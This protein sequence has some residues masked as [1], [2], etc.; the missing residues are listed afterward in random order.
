VKGKTLQ[1]TLLFNL[2]QYNQEGE[3]PTAING[4]DLPSWECP[5][6]SAGNL[7]P[8]G[9]ISYLTYRWRRCKLVVA[10]E[11]VVK[12]ASHPG[13]KL[14]KDLSAQ[15]WEC[16]I[17]YRKTK[18]GNFPVRLSLNRS[19]WRDAD[20]FLQSS[21][22]GDRPRILDWIA[23]L[24]AEDEIDDLVHL[25]IL[26]LT[27][28]NA[29]PLGW[30]SSQFSAPLIYLKDKNLW[31]CLSIA[32]RIAE[33]HQ[34]VFRSFKG[35][36][37]ATLAEALKNG[38]PNKI[39]N[40]LNGESRYWA[41]LDRD[42]QLLLAELPRDRTVDGNGTT[43]GLKELPTWTKTVQ[44]AARRAFTDSIA[45]IRNYEARAKALRSLEYQLA[46][47]RGEGQESKTKKQ[48]KKDQ[49]NQQLTLI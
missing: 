48:A 5:L 39:A 15:Q 7:T 27:V 40:N 19:L 10:G 46:K 16:G 44:N 42:F 6:P 37:Y 34:Q 31:Q 2:M 20:T 17:P 32:I 18:K 23:D 49:E 43:Y 12:A 45:S 33:E 22:A 9:Y 4:E 21:E 1:N 26:G 30:D 41:T 11:N 8:N 25:Q 3:I 29:K 38:E 24:K 36:P 13:D 14:P 47:L 28:D 35:S